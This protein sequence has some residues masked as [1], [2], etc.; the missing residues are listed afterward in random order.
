M[1]LGHAKI[2]VPVPFSFSFS[3][4]GSDRWNVDAVASDGVYTSVNAKGNGGIGNKNA[5][6]SWIFD[7]PDLSKFILKQVQP[8]W[9]PFNSGDSLSASVQ[10]DT[11]FVKKGFG[12]GTEYNAFA[13]VRWSSTS[14]A[15]LSLANGAFRGLSRISYDYNK[16]SV[17]YGGPDLG[18][19]FAAE[20]AAYA[21]FVKG[22]NIV[23][24]RVNPE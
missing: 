2:N 6:E 5:D 23:L 8:Q 7:D 9:Q 21:A 12:F 13:R 4:P 16:T 24:N 3:R 19:D 11:F 14:T 10:F 1:R 22:Q 17:Q 18:P 20:S 15:T